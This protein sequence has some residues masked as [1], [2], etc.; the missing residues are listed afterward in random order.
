MPPSQP[1]SKV[2]RI[3]LNEKN[4]TI[5][6]QVGLDGFYEDSPIE[7]SGQATQPNGTVAT[8]YA[9]R[10]MP[11]AVQKADGTPEEAVVTVTSVSAVPPNKFDPE[12]PITVVSRAAEVWITTL[13]KEDGI[14]PEED[15]SSPEKVQPAWT[16]KTYSF[17]V[18]EPGKAPPSW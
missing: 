11:K 5:S 17:A 2:N 9:I 4:Q 15:G 16:A 18:C 7:I 1:L 12:M 14:R 6:L 8:F 13:D 10:T 3:E